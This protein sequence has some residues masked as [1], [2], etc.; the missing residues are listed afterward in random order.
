LPAFARRLLNQTADDRTAALDAVHQDYADSREHWQLMLDAFEGTGGFANGEYLWR[1]RNETPEDYDARRAM[2]RYHNYVETI[3]D[4]YVHHVFTQEAERQTTNAELQAW[5]ADVDGEGTSMTDFLRDRVIPLALA[6]GHT[7]VLVDATPDAPTGPSVADQRARPILL[8]YPA[9]SIR[10]WRTKRN[11]VSGVKLIEAVPDGSIV[12]EAAIGDDARQFLIWDPEGWARFTPQ[13]DLVDAG[14]P[15]LGLVPFEVVKPKPSTLKA[16]C[17]RS[18][19]SHGRIVQALYNRMSEE[20][21]VVRN[22]A[23]SLLT[24]EVSDDGDVEQARKQLGTEIG[25]SRALVVRGKTSYISPDM[26]VPEQLRTSIDQ[27][28]RELY[29]VA[30][31]RYERDSL[32]AESAEAIR[33]QFRE[34][35]EMLQGLAAELQ[36]VE[37]R[38][39][40]FFF[41]WTSATPEQAQQ[42]FEAADISINYADEF[43]L[44]DLR[45]DLDSWMQAISMDLGETFTKKLKKKTVRRIEPELPLD[46]AEQIDQEIDAQE[47]QPQGSTVAGAAD[48]LRKGAEQRLKELIATTSGGG[49]A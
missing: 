7:G 33:L 5:W 48:Q 44:A 42:A 39:A 23:F 9:T 12:D 22:Q 20:D 8:A 31:M 21:E 36:R 49:G 41:A 19:F 25:T 30:H 16:F 40:R 29:R 1:Y 24:V 35:N 4:V 26:A 18:L 47:H 6:T 43:F 34:L 15:G 11:T 10:D 28:I 38:L 13:G 17:G 37:L 2:A 27:I 45:L 32:Q 14:T 3:I 46:E